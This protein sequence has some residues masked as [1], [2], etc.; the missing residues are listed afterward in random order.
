LSTTRLPRVHPHPPPE[1]D[2]AGIVGV[3][4]YEG[5]AAM[6]TVRRVEE[7]D[8]AATTTVRRVEE[9]DAEAMTEE[10]VVVEEEDAG[11]TTEEEDVEA[12]AVA[13]FVRRTTGRQPPRKN[14]FSPRE[15]KWTDPRGWPNDARV[16]K[17]RTRRNRGTSRSV[18]KKTRRNKPGRKKKRSSDGRPS[19]GPSRRCVCVVMSSLLSLF[20]LAH[21]FSSATPHF[22]GHEKHRKRKGSGSAHV[23]SPSGGPSGRSA[24]AHQDLGAPETA[25]T[26]S[27]SVSSATRQRVLAPRRSATWRT[28]RRT[29]RWWWRTR[30]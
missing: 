11:A 17:K 16:N 7:E 29:S 19:L 2:G 30:P 4:T 25:S 14:R 21:T 24:R 10:V 23:Q 5:A 26:T 18:R 8:A 13:A 3:K 15:A 9:E 27:R 1:A 6:T 28:R 20:T 12:A 22:I